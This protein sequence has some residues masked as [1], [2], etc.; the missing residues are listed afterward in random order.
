MPKMWYS[1][2][3]ILFKKLLE[4]NPR[5]FSKNKY[6][7]MTEREYKVEEFRPRECTSHIY[8]TVCNL[9]VFILNIEKCA[10]NHLNECIARIK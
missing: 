1:H 10:N 6:I 8:C 5:F 9:L 2:I 3:R 4:Y 7:H